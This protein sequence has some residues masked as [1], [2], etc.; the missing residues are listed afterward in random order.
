MKANRSISLVSLLTVITCGLLLALVPA[1][2]GQG[3]VSAGATGVVRGADGSPL[4]NVTV[5]AVHIPTNTTYRATTSAAGRYTFRNLIVGGPYTFSTTA[6]GFQASEQTNV[7]T[8][9]GTDIDVSFGLQTESP[10]VLTLDKF[11]VTAESDQLDATA[12]GAGSIITNARMQ[13][14]PSAKRSIGDMARTNPLVT[15]RQAITDRDDQMIT[16]VG[17]NNRYNSILLDGARINDQF[18]LGHP[19]VF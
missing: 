9:L 14:V 11:V 19:I 8:Q 6:S 2:N 18:G 7:V 12:S 1:V 5:Q 17:Q 16:A 10:D 15:F 3:L 4:P 13:S